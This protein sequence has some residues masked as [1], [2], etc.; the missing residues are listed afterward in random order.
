VLEVDV[1]TTFQR[2]LYMIF[3]VA[4]SWNLFLNPTKCVVIRFSCHFAG[5][6]TLGGG[7]TYRLVNS[8]LEFV[9]SRRDPGDVVDTHLRFQGHV[10]DMVCR[11]AGS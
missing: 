4:T 6:N 5:F 1:I 3:E 2:N 7:T 11:L 10:R 9:D 8:V